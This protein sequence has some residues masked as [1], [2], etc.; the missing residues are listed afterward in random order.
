MK[1]TADNNKISLKTGK[2]FQQK[3]SGFLAEKNI[4]WHPEKLPM[5]ACDHGLP[6]VKSVG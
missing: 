1:F 2:N 3:K 6:K 4:W 5:T